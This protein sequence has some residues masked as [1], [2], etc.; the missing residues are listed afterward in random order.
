MKTN[1]AKSPSPLFSTL[2]RVER[3]QGRIYS[4]I[5]LCVFEDTVFCIS[6]TDDEFAAELCGDDQDSAQKLFDLLCSES[7]PSYQLFDVIS[8]FKRELQHK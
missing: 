8:D 5:E 7:V 1:T 3:S 4:L 2:L 6:V